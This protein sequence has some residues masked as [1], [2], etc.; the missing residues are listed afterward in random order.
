LTRL[1][2]VLD[3]LKVWLGIDP[4]PLVEDLPVQD[5]HIPYNPPMMD[6]GR[7]I[8]EYGS[9][10]PMGMI[11]SGS[12]CFSIANPQ[13]FRVVTVMEKPQPFRKEWKCEFCGS[14]HPYE[15]LDESGHPH[16]V[17]MCEQCGHPKTVVQMAGVR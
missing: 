13:D 9:Q 7:A 1:T 11:S 2:D 4:T 6:Y 17:G 3:T 15:E 16:H 8:Y 12:A 14:V 10:W 5:T